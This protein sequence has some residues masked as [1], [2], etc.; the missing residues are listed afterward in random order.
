MSEEYNKK[1]RGAMLDD[2]GDVLYFNCEHINC[3]ENWHAYATAKLLGRHVWLMHG[4]RIAEYWK[5]GKRKWEEQERNR[6]T[7]EREADRAD[8]LMTNPCLCIWKGV[9]MPRR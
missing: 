9:I 4:I 8:F 7:R 6:L 1:L 3:S 2:Y 5:E